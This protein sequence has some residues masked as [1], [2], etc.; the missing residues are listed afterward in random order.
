[1]PSRT[2]TIFDGEGNLYKF[3]V[4]DA[5]G[6]RYNQ[7]LTEAGAGAT[8]KMSEAVMPKKEA[9]LLEKHLRSLQYNSTGVYKLEGM[10]RPFPANFYTGLPIKLK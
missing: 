7:S 2:Y 8:G 10:K 4:T 5:K 3:G 1:M 9:H 6:V